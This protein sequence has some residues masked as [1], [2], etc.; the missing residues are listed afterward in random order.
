MSNLTRLESISQEDPVIGDPE[1][2]ITCASDQL[3]EL[4]LVSEQTKA[5]TPA[6]VVLDGGQ[7]PRGPLYYL[8]D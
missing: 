4:G 6:G 8:I 1:A 5:M 3:I 2:A 7:I